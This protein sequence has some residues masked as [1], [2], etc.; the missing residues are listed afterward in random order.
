MTSNTLSGKPSRYI[1]AKYIR[2]SQDD[3][4]SESHSIPHQRLLLDGHIENMD[5]PGAQVL[6]FVDNGFTGTNVE[7]TNVVPSPLLGK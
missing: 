4:I 2:L 1:I 3:A 6:E 7:R 5:I